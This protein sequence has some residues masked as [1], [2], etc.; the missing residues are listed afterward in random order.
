MIALVLTL[1]IVVPF[2]ALFF[3]IGRAYESLDR[4]ARMYRIQ[5][6]HPSHHH[7]YTTARQRRAAHLRLLPAPFDYEGEAS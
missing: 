7:R 3:C 6:R 2:A 4:D 5:S 1:C